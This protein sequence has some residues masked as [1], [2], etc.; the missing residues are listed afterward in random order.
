[1]LQKD[2]QAIVLLVDVESLRVGRKARTP[3]ERSRNLAADGLCG[4][5]SFTVD[6][7][8][9]WN[10]GLR[11]GFTTIVP[12]FREEIAGGEHAAELAVPVVKRF[13]VV[14]FVDEVVVALGISVVGLGE[15]LFGE[16]GS[17]GNASYAAEGEKNRFLV[18]IGG[19]ERISAG[20]LLEVLVKICEEVLTKLLGDRTGTIGLERAIV[21]SIASLDDG[22]A[23]E[24][25]VLDGAQRSRMK[26]AYCV[27][28]V[29]KIVVRWN[30]LVFFE[31]SI[32]V[33]SRGVGRSGLKAGKDG[34]KIVSEALC[35]GALDAGESFCVGAYACESGFDGTKFYR[36]G[37][38]GVGRDKCV[39]VRLREG[40]LS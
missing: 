15:G 26:I 21:K 32:G 20:E 29:T 35:F 4:F 5:G 36:R 19:N 16:V 30:D 33:G 9:R 23:R 22:C 12:A 25:D 13:A 17:K 14:V 38:N 40:G 28:R 8:A 24:S 39:K 1:M 31:E 10:Y 2:V 34:E 37:G 3:R 11:V 18:Q 6:V 27:P 7:G